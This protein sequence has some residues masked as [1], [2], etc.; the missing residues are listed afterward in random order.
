[1]IACQA[2]YQEYRKEQQRTRNIS[3]GKFLM[4]RLASAPDQLKK[5]DHHQ[6]PYR[7]PARKRRRGYH[8][9]RIVEMNIDRG[10]TIFR[11]AVEH[12]HQHWYKQ[13]IFNFLHMKEI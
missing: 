13:E 6:Q 7:K 4:Y 11:H 5:K 8:K 2:Q 10:G 9:E 1:M 3:N 12:Q